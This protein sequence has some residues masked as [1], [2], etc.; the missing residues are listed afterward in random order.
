M[1]ILGSPLFFDYTDPVRSP[2]SR[3]LLI[4]MM[5]V[6][7][8]QAFA[9]AAMLGCAFSHQG[10]ATHQALGK[11]AM[12]DEAMATCHE[13]EQTDK[14]PTSHNCKHCSVCHLASALL[15]PAIDATP[16]LPVTHSTIPHADDAFIGFIPDSPER[17]PRIPFA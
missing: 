16:I 9:S 14:T 3:F 11:Q 10:Q 8:V 17:P 5:L 15:V 4:L 7:P 13:S 12:T 2:I 1:G 6:L